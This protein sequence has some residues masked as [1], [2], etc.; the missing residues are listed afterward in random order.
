MMDRNNGF[1][2]GKLPKAVPGECRGRCLLLWPRIVLDVGEATRDGNMPSRPPRYPSKR[3]PAN[4]CPIP[5]EFI[6]PTREFVRAEAITGDISALARL[7]IC[8][9]SMLSRLDSRSRAVLDGFARRLCLAVWLALLSCYIQ[10]WPY[11]HTLGLFQLM[12]TAAAFGAMAL[13]LWKHEHLKSRTLT[14]WDEGM[15]FNALSLLTH[16]LARLMP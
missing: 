12:C 9:W 13:A 5:I 14:F 3:G 6:C 11:Q 1:L 8:D 7:R 2:A 15:A 4:P 16:G 10:R